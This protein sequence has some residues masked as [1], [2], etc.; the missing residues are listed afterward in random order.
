V[1]ASKR[2]L[3]EEEREAF[4][5]AYRHAS[6]NWESVYERAARMLAV[7]R[8][9]LKRYYNENLHYHLMRSDYEGLLRYLTLASD[10][11]YLDKVRKDIWM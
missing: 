1:W 5:L 3:F 8:T 2:T 10:F 9:F 11:G 7:E 6:E 4:H